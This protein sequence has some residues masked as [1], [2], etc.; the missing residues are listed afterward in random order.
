MS[1]RVSIL[2]LLVEN[3]SKERKGFDVLKLSI[4]ELIKFN[5]GIQRPIES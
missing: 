4:K 5:K 2:S 1:E 3:L